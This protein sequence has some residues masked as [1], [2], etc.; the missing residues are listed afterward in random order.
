M[1]VASGGDNEQE[2]SPTI[3]NYQ[4]YFGT[5]FGSFVTQGIFM[6]VRGNHDIQSAGSYTDYDGTVHNTG[7]A[8]W[9]YFGANA[10]MYNIEGKKLTDYSY[11]LGTWHIIGLDQ[12]NGSVTSFLDFLLRP[13]CAFQYDCSWFTGTFHL[14]IRSF[15]GNC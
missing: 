1:L 2:S 8:Y 3:S 12:L 4:N 9:D 6:Q 5:T 10:H 11:D 13:G 15:H 14:L 7:A